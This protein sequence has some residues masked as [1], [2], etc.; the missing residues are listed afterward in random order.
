MQRNAADVGARTASVLVNSCKQEVHDLCLQEKTERDL[1][2]ESVISGEAGREKTR[3]T[4]GAKKPAWSL[5]ACL[6]QVAAE[7][8]SSFL[9]DD[10]L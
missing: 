6:A 8:W 1:Q 9:S 7:D 5:P 2:R 4:G 10:L 3:E